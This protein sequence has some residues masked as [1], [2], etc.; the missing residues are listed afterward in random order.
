MESRIPL[1]T[2]NI[3][4][5]YALFGLVLLVTSIAAFLYVH[6]TSNELAFEAYIEYAELDTKEHPTPVEK[7]RKE[8]IEKRLEIAVKDRD[9]YNY[10]LSAL[11]GVGLFLVGFGFWKWEKDVQ[12]RQDDLL[13]LQIEKAKQDLK[14]PQRVPFRVPKS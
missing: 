8:I 6:K 2:D 14:K 1:P 3:Y 9:F 5:F 11:I 4:K 12:P 13:D 10:A 7:K